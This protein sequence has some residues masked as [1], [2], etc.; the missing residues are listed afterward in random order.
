MVFARP[1]FADHGTTAICSIHPP[2]LE[3]IVFFFEA[4]NYG[5]FLLI[6]FVVAQRQGNTFLRPLASLS[7]CLPFN[8]SRLFLRGFILD[9][10]FWD[11]IIGR[12]TT[13]SPTN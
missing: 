7:Y 12:A 9:L 6:L 8:V 11:D 13:I 3:L 4:E 10:F 1:W 2:N 5:I